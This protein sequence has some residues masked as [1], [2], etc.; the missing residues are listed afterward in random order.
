[1]NETYRD[2]FH[3]NTNFLDLLGESLF[4]KLAVAPLI[5]DLSATAHFK[6]LTKKGMRIV[7]ES[8]SSVVLT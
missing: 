3:E 6:A 1:M 4:E 2:P 7:E 5:P 8:D